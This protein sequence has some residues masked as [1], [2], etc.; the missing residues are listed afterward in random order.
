MFEKEIGDSAFS[1]YRNEM[2]K[3]LGKNEL[4]AM[5]VGCVYAAR[6]RARDLDRVDSMARGD[7][8][9]LVIWVIGKEDRDAEDP[10]S[11]SSFGHYSQLIIGDDIA[12]AVDS[13]CHHANIEHPGQS[14]LMAGLVSVQRHVAIDFE[15]LKPEERTMVHAMAFAY[16]AMVE[17]MGNDEQKAQ[18][19]DAS[20]FQLVQMAMTDFGSEAIPEE[21]RERII[22]RGILCQ[23]LT[24][25]ARAAAVSVNPLKAAILESDGVHITD[26]EFYTEACDFWLD[27][28]GED[29]DCELGCEVLIPHMLTLTTKLGGDA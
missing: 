18:V 24:V 9:Y 6:D 21:L 2:E 7:D 16:K 1:D 4:S 26:P 22:R 5:L 20:T 23:A 10:I 29:L 12:G 25:D 27:G 3:R 13:L 17:S 19:K 15:K 8:R 14:L 28:Q 11:A